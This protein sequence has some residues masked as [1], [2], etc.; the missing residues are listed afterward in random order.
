MTRLVAEPAPYPDDGADVFAASAH[1][2]WAIYLDSGRP[3]GTTGR[4]DILLAQ[5]TATLVTRAGTTEIQRRGRPA[6]RSRAD[7]FDLLRR[8]LHEHRPACADLEGLPF[9][10]GAAGYFAYDLGRRIERLP[11]VAR[12]AE[13]LPEMAVGIYPWAVVT[14]HVEQRRWLVWNDIDGAPRLSGLMQTFSRAPSP[15]RR[16]S[17]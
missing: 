1:L 14:D 2:P 17:G 3:R 16:A 11:S 4:W 5:P 12:D 7:P 10:G 9:R 13:A 8:A 6:E 15:S